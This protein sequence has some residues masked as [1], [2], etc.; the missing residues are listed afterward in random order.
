[1][2]QNPLL[3][4]EVSDPTLARL[5]LRSTSE[6][7]DATRPSFLANDRSPVHWSGSDWDRLETNREPLFDMSAV[8]AQFDHASFLRDGYAVLKRSHDTENYRGMDSG[9]EIWSGTQRQVAEFRL[10]A[11]RLAH[12]RPNAADKIAHR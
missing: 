6:L 5:L 1:M 8:A 9:V 7:A 11:N 10:D 2:P 12:P 4:P 3:I